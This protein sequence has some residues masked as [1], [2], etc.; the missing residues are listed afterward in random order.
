MQTERTR[1]S[2]AGW[3]PNCCKMA[4]CNRHLKRQHEKLCS[5]LVIYVKSCK[6]LCV[7][8]NYEEST[9]LLMCLLNWM[10]NN[11]YSCFDVVT[12]NE[13][14]SR[15]GSISVLHCS[16]VLNCYLAPQNC[17]IKT[18]AITKE[19]LTSTFLKGITRSFLE[20]PVKYCGATIKYVNE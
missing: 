18:E 10:I 4:T 11:T 2:F 9:I 1:R 20:V 8:L 19:F 13:Q 17:R 16:S 5:S 12:G 7:K 15:W 3:S 6:V 14:W